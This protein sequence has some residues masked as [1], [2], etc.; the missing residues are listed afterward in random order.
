MRISGSLL[1][2]IYCFVL[3]EST[4]HEVDFSSKI[5]E[6][7]KAE[8]FFELSLWPK[9]LSWQKSLYFYIDPHSWCF[10]C[11]FSNGWGLSLFC[12]LAYYMSL[13]IP[14]QCHSL[15]TTTL[16]GVSGSTLYQ[17]LG[18]CLQ[19]SRG[20]LMANEKKTKLVLMILN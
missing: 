11:Y 12:L 17:H 8:Q 14:G 4:C 10:L 2:Q 7:V 15:Y 13:S 9:K 1:C 6:L 20:L 16:F 3:K 5:K 19:F 18:R